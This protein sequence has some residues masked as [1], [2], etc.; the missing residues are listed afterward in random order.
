MTTTTRFVVDHLIEIPAQHVAVMEMLKGT[1]DDEIARV[2]ALRDELKA[3]QSVDQTLETATA[4]AADAKAKN[5]AAEKALADANF[6]AQQIA[7]KAATLLAQ[8]TA[9]AQQAASDAAKVAADRSVFEADKANATELMD[10]RSAA[11]DLRE[12]QLALMAAKV[13]EDQRQLAIEREAFN[14]KLDSLKV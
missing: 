9:Q 4:A 10:Q 2:T 1:F 7:D 13:G 11:L 5:E 3:R 8:A 12:S 14:K 6:Q